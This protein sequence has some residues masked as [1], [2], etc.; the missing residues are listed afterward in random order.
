MLEAAAFES[1]FA[2]W[3]GQFELIDGQVV[4][5]DGK[6]ARRSHDQGIGREA[7]HLVSA[8]ATG[9]GIALGQR[10]VDGKSNEITAIPPC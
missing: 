10:T 3:V 9:N 4:A 7:V 8:W 5:L 6:P 2:H 1:G